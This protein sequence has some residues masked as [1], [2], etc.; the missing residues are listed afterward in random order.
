LA[1][2]ASAAV[3]RQEVV[4]GP[5]SQSDGN[6]ARILLTHKLDTI[7]L[8]FLLFICRGNLKHDLSSYRIR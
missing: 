5:C 1:A 3:T 2:A 8:L 6:Q 4:E 7:F